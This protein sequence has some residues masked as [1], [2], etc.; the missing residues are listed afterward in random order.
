MP[1]KITTRKT[2]APRTVGTKT[3]A[4]KSTRKQNTNLNSQAYFNKVRE[5]AYEIYLQRGT[6]HGDH[7]S[8]WLAAENEIRR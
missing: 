8:D 1:K 6:R 5:R 7:M 3:T 4:R 2:A